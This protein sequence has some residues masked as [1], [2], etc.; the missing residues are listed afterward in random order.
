MRAT[1]QHT[2]GNPSSAR[3]SCS[4][5]P[6]AQGQLHVVRVLAQAPLLS[7]A[8]RRAAGDARAWRQVALEELASAPASAWRVLRKSSSVEVRA[9]LRLPA[10]A[11]RRAAAAGLAVRRWPAQQGRAC[12]E[13]QASTRL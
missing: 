7:P 8:V 1:L 4:H 9:R 3:S 13:G 5:F 2:A 12:A 6:P 10:P 11:P